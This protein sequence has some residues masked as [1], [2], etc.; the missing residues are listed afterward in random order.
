M[1]YIG[2]AHVAYP[3]E[4]TRFNRYHFTMY[5]YPKKY[6]SLKDFLEYYSFPESETERLTK[7][8]YE[9]STFRLIKL[10]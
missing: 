4:G 8:Y 3:P 9:E 5:H 1:N 10:L 2:G 6:Y 7:L